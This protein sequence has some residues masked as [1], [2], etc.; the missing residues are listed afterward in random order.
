MAGAPAA[1]ASGGVDY[2]GTTLPTAVTSLPANLF[3]GTGVNG[4]TQPTWYQPQTFTPT[5]VSG[6]SNEYNSLYNAVYG[7]SGIESLGNT[8]QTGTLSSDYLAGTNFNQLFANARDQG[9]SQSNQNNIQYNP[10]LD[11][12]F[13]TLQAQGIN[14]NSSINDVNNLL[15]NVDNQKKSEQNSNV[16]G[17]DAANTTNANSAGYLQ[18]A[19]IAQNQ[20]LGEL[21][22]RGLLQSY[23]NGGMGTADMANLSN[24]LQ[25]AQNDQGVGLQDELSGLTN[26]Q[27]QFDLSQNALQNAQGQ[28]SQQ[29]ANAQP[30]LADILGLG[31]SAF[32][33][34]KSL[35]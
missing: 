13:G 16:A 26:A 33:D 24:N 10:Q 28:F 32:N 2:G 25:N 14:G 5:D 9:G 30:G 19:A 15:N 1:N 27:Q 17:Y 23:M 20:L 35:F 29:K 8:Q 21:N 22:Q 6:L 4:L 7:P 31:A 12:D 18:Q 34:V 11:A 3:Q